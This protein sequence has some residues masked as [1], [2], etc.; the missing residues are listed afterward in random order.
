M[1][2]EQDMKKV[3]KAIRQFIK[4]ME[5]EIFKEDIDA[6][7]ERLIKK[8]KNKLQELISAIEDMETGKMLQ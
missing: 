2:Q 1:L 8:P 4:D 6:I 7:E 3:A 5:L